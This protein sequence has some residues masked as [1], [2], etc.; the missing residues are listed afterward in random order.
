V[1][2]WAAGAAWK[3]GYLESSASSASSAGP[4]PKYTGKYTPEGQSEQLVDVVAEK[5]R[6]AEKAKAVANTPPAIPT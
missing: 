1:D 6:A 3:I 5:M 2:R 4:N